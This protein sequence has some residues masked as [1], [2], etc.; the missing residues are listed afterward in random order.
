MKKWVMLAAMLA[1]VIVVAAPAIAQ[2]TQGFSESGPTSGPASPAVAISNTGNNANLCPSA[3]QAA[4]TGNVSEEQGASQYDLT[5]GDLS[6]AG[7]SITITPATTSDCTQ[8]T[9]QAAAAK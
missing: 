7:S 1:V 3:Q 6:F 2:V 5:Q 9:S 4:Q 8:S